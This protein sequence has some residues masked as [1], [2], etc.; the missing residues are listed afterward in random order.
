MA[1]TGAER[2]G[3]GQQHLAVEATAPPPFDTAVAAQDGTKVE[4]SG[5]ANHEREATRP[6]NSSLA[7]LKSK[8]GAALAGLG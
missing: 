7:T 2:L 8:W 1:A 3:Q 5:E 6:G 4:E